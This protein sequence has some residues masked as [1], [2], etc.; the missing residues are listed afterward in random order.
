ML[1]PDE[2]ASRFPLWMRVLLVGVLVILVSGAGLF[3]YRYYTTPKIMTIA[4]GSVDG[5]AARMMS[6]I[7]VRP[8]SLSRW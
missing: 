3:A 8:R 4:A 2:V 7:A 6:A 1:D 5:E